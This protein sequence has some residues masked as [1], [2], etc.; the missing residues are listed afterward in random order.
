M[1]LNE[2]R[3]QG[4]TIEIQK[5]T[6][7]FQQL[8]FTRNLKLKNDS[9]L[10]A[11]KIAKEES[12]RK[13][14][15]YK[16]LSSLNNQLENAQLLLKKKNLQLMNKEQELIDSIQELQKER[17]KV[18]D[19]KNKYNELNNLIDNM[20]ATSHENPSNND[21]SSEKLLDDNAT[22]KQNS[23]MW[24]TD[25]DKKLNKQ[26]EEAKGH[27]LVPIA[28]SYYISQ[29]FGKR[30]GATTIEHSGI[31]LIGKK[32]AYA[33]SI[34][35]GEVVSVFSL[36]ESI[37]ILIRHGSYISVYCNLVSTEVHRGQHVRAGE[38][39]G[40]IGIDNDGEIVLYFQ[41]RYETEKLNPEEWLSIVKN[42]E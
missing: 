42:S 31:S 1:M 26:I 39:L 13:D 20:F 25:K 6:I 22:Y 38:K 16:S 11:L 28:G 23:S 12:E 35:N 30:I 9:L 17:R 24:L 36:S 2:N 27:L 3:L 5:S 8:E 32:G 14:L 19:Y 21:H 41:L 15:A 7:H 29:H 18:I 37:N 40:K 33:R 4:R 10:D 34:F